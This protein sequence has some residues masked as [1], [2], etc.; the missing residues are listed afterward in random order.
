MIL[1]IL[2][3]AFSSHAFASEQVGTT[4]SI[5]QLI[6]VDDYMKH[7]RLKVSPCPTP[8][9]P[10]VGVRF[11]YWEPS[12]FMET[13]KA[14]GDYVI[15]EFGVPVHNALKAFKFGENKTSTSSFQ[16]FNGSNLQFNEAHLYDVP[17]KLL[18]EAVMCAGTFG[19]NTVIRYLS[20]VDSDRWRRGKMGFLIH[21]SNMVAS[22]TTCIRAVNLINARSMGLIPDQIQMVHP[23]KTGLLPVSANLSVYK[24]LHARDGRYVWIYWR[25]R[26][27]CRSVSG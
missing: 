26:D 1:W 23:Y 7:S 6:T 27:C 17:L 24:N 8:N 5:A 15:Q 9:P 2:L 3:L 14:P 19:D 12:L 11:Q 4:R 22:A 20:E 16:S 10:Y 18:Q 21:V 25:Y 13:V